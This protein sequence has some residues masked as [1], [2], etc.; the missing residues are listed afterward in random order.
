MMP[1]RFEAQ[2]PGG[3][4]V[5]VSAGEGP[6]VVLLHGLGVDR[7]IWN[8][9]LEPLAEEH[10][11][12]A[13]DQRGHGESSPADRPYAR[14]EDLLAVLDHCGIERAQ[15]VGS[16]MG[17]EV[18]LDAALAHP[19]R[20]A[21]LVLLDSSLGGHAWSRAWRDSIRSIREAAAE[22]GVDAAK[23]AWFEHPL[24]T[25]ACAGGDRGA[26]L[27]AAIRADSGRRW[28]EK[29]PALPLIPPAAGRLREVKCQ[30]TIVVGELDL[31]DFH[32]IARALGEGIPGAR[33]IE[34]LGVG[35]LPMLEQPERTAGL[36]RSILAQRAAGA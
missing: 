3:R 8:D 21:G 30:A 31:E 10:R 13:F 15:L 19:A 9:V 25:P 24:F 28:L 12:I 23:Y 11:V 33:R 1:E 6:A 14:H 5:G 22:R 36:L 17:G 4:L 18:A 20:V 27:E 34:L 7:S 2:V 32:A 16:S 35:H 29:D 26:R